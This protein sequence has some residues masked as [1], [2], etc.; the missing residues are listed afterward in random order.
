[1]LGQAEYE[2][3]DRSTDRQTGPEMVVKCPSFFPSNYRR[4]KI[5]AKNKDIGTKEEEMNM[6]DKKERFRN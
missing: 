1:L 4:L 3:T 5:E 2:Q 6:R